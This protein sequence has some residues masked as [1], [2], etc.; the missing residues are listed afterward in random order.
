VSEIRVNWIDAVRSAWFER[1][2]RGAWSLTAAL[3]AALGTIRLL[4]SSFA[5]AAAASVAAVI[6]ACATGAS[7][8]SP[9]SWRVCADGR[10]QVRWNAGAP[11]DAQAV[12]VSTFLIVLRHAGRDLAV[13]RDAAPSAAFRRLSVAMRWPGARQSLTPSNPAHATERT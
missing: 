11:V 6:A 1:L 2:R 9:A 4:D 12:F 7:K 10:A 3:A 5:A 13:W 8:T